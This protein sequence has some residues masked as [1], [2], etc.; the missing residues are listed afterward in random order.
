MVIRRLLGAWSCS[1]ASGMPGWP[2]NRR[3]VDSFQ[4]ERFDPR[5]P[6]LH[7]ANLS[8]VLTGDLVVLP[9]AHAKVRRSGYRKDDT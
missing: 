8:P 7:N 5:N 6:A 2:T 4:V 9:G 1:S 3:Q